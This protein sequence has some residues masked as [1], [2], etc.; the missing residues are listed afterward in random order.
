MLGVKLFIFFYIYKKYK[1]IFDD[2]EIQNPRP[3]FP[4]SIAYSLTIQRHKLSGNVLQFYLE[5]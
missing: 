4:D 3:Q 5:M 2:V 1:N